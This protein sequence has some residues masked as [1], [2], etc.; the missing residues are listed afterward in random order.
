MKKALIAAAVVIVLAILVTVNVRRGRDRGVE[1]E[2][3]PV[4]RRELVEHVSGSGRIEARKSVS[5]TS[6]VIGKVLEVAA[7]EG[8]RVEK[9]DLILRIDPGERT[10]ALEQ[11]KAV[12][13][14]AKARQALAEA[15]LRKAEFEL[16]RATDLRANGLMSDQGLEAAETNREVADANVRAA[17]EDVRNSEA[18]VE[19]GEYELAKAEF[20]AEISGVIV[21]L[22]VEEG[23][24][25]L[26]G[27]LYNQGSAMAVIADLSVM[28]AHV[29]VDETEVVR[30]EKDQSAIVEVDAFP[31][32]KLAGRVSEVGNSAYN[33]GPLGSQEAKDFLVRIVLEN[34]S[35]SLRPGLSARAEIETSRRESALAIP[36]EAL[37]IRDPAK[38]R[39][40]GRKR[41]RDEGTD[42]GTDEGDASS[43]SKEKEGVFLL[44]D[45]KA[46]FVPVTT[47]IAGDRHFEVLA[48]VEEG[49]VVIRGPFE[50]IRN[51][52]TGDDVKVK[53]QSGR[54]SKPPAAEDPPEESEAKANGEG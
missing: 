10:A 34:L 35:E 23:E 17:R 40:N 31:E 6:S 37:T 7:E 14:R 45:E 1:V 33:A 25:V 38:Q 53:K 43:E 29:L 2:I 22:S 39:T 36:I 48:G 12:L 28:E 47:G 18:G 46:V 16:R 50:A 15:E 4:E 49:D 19:Y 44:R 32:L 51:L 20:R 3:A 5:L 8:D 26:A 11:A 9:G 52:E 24:N 54:A 13:A 27:D 30:V 42:E 21:R 41:D